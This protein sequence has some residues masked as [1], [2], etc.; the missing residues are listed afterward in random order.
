MQIQSERWN[1]CAR[2]LIA[3]RN[4]HTLAANFSDHQGH[5][6]LPEIHKMATSMKMLDF[7]QQYS[8]NLE[9]HPDN[10]TSK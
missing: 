3:G 7:N 9:R 10:Y 2:P 4:A 5:L 6:C 8:I 1:D